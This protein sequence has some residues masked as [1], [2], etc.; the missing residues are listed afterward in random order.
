MLDTA[1]EGS[2]VFSST[3]KM[4]LYWGGDKDFL[5]NVQETSYHIWPL[6]SNLQNSWLIVSKLPPLPS[7]QVTKYKHHFRVST[8][9]GGNPLDEGGRT[10]GLEAGGLVFFPDRVFHACLHHEK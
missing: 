3:G 4:A 2:C 8:S 9:G 6:L 10:G 7:Q 5:L 1:L